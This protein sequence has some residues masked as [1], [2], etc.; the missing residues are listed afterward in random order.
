MGRC[1]QKVDWMLHAGFSFFL[2]SVASAFIYSKCQIHQ[3][4]K[5]LGL[6]DFSI[7]IVKYFSFMSLPCLL[8]PFLSTV[9]AEC[10][11]ILVLLLTLKNRN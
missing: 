4:R 9:G 1:L 3:S 2:S 8:V 6:Y 7:Q 11:L 5:L 10:F